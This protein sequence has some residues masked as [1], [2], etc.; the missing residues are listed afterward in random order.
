ME[1]RTKVLIG[2]AAATA[3]T[4][5]L[6]FEHFLG[7]AEVANIS[8]EEIQKTINLASQQKEDTCLAIRNHL[9]T[10]LAIEKERM[11][12]YWTDGELKCAEEILKEYRNA[13]RK[14]RDQMWFMFIDLRKDFDE[15]ERPCTK[16]LTF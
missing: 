6:C 4:C 15:I 11:A 1:E 7:E 16:D 8:Q 10:A 12:K 14:R 3:A 13:S 9:L 5:S 2:L